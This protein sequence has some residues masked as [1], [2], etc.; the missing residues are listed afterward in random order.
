MRFCVRLILIS[1]LLLLSSSPFVF[2]QS[3]PKVVELKGEGIQQVDANYI[4]SVVGVT[5][6]QPVDK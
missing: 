2:A 5:V 3:Y 1:A 4:L 6:D